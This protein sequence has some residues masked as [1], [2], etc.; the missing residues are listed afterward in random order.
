MKIPTRRRLLP[1]IPLVSTSDVA[2][3]LLIFFLSTTIL[4]V[5]R[6]ILLALPGPGERVLL[7]AEKHVAD[8]IVGADG[9]VRLGAVR[10]PAD[11]L[12]GAIAVRLA[13]DPGLLVRITVDAKAPYAALV[14][15]LDQVKLA[16]ARQLSLR[17]DTET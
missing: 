8:V 15:T 9:T 14:T 17:T 1:E 16:G 12:R 10:V 4:N 6:G 3:L 2:F 13:T 7:P 5:E 11:Q